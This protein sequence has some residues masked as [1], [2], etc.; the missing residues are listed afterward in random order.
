MHLYEE[1][2]FQMHLIQNDQYHVE[3]YQVVENP[4]EK[5]LLILN[6]QKGI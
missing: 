4:S 1:A 3:I 2:S 5:K 6:Y